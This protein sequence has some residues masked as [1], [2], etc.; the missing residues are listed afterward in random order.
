MMDLGG[1]LTGLAGYSS[2]KNKS[3]DIKTGIMICYASTSVEFMQKR[4][5]F[6]SVARTILQLDDLPQVIPSLQRGR[7]GLL[8]CFIS[9]NI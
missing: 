3:I 5:E 6:S 9:E 7:G 1:I 8:D 4:Q 2:G